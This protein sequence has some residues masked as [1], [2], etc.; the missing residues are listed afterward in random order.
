MSTS[1]VVT[2]A[3]T[4]SLIAYAEP[5]R[6]ASRTTPARERGVAAAAQPRD[7]GDVLGVSCRLLVIDH[8]HLGL[9]P[10]AQLEAVAH[11]ELAAAAEPA[12]AVER[13]APRSIR[14]DGL[15]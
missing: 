14:G 9:A 12:G 7:G 6:R 8:A 2:C 4:A 11:H 15:L 1:G 10:L 5:W 3:W 13:E